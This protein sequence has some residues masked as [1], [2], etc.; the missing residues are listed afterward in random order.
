MGSRQ[1]RVVW[2]AGARS[3]LEEA[4]EFV[5]LDSPK[6]AAELVDRLLLAADSL[7]TLPD[8][9]RVV[10]E[11]E[12]PQIRELLVDPYRLIYLT[13]EAR[14]VV[15]AILHQRQDFERSLGGSRRQE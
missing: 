15:L 8:R 5:A 2:A 12:D 3:Q 7:A 14:V 10:P 1:R 11:R 9:G 6:N 13:G 4:V